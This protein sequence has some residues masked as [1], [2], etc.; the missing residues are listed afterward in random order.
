MTQ[1]TKECLEDVKVYFEIEASEDNDWITTR[2]IGFQKVERS[3]KGLLKELE[4]IKNT[5]RTKILNYNTD[6]KGPYPVG[7]DKWIAEEWQPKAA[8]LG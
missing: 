2:W 5:G 6:I 1:H 8:E 4:V 7:I 3:K